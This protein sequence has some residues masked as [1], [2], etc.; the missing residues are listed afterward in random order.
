MGRL[1]AFSAAT[2]ARNRTPTK[3]L[4]RRTPYEA[5]YGVV[6]DVSN[7][8]AFGGPSPTAEPATKLKKLNDRATM[9]YFV[10]YE[11]G[12]GGY[13]VWDP[14]RRLVIESRDITFFEDAH[15]TSSA[16]ADHQR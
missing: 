9:G 12:G 14:K 13:R 3:A 6:P 15:P 1:E 16:S 11:Y 5:V 10:G 2:Y 4:G 8:R 7:L